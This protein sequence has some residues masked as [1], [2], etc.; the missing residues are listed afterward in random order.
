M[1]FLYI[2]NEAL[3]FTGIYDHINELTEFTNFLIE[4]E[5]GLSCVR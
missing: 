1:L 5:V 4:N 3:V 2:Y